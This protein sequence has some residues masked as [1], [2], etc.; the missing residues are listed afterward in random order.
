MADYDKHGSAVDAVLSSLASQL[1]AL[2][3]RIEDLTTGT[4]VISHGEVA[5]RS[6]LTEVERHLRSAL[7][8]IS[9]ARRA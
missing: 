5:D 9:R 3:C 7:R 1:E 8:E 2:I 4:A 6:A